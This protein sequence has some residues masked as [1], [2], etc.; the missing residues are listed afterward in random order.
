VLG[1]QRD[2]QSRDALVVRLQLEAE[3]RVAE[4][5]LVIARRCVLLSCPLDVGKHRLTYSFSLR[6]DPVLECLVGAVHEH[7]IEKGASIKAHRVVGPA[8]LQRGLK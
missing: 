6:L 2:Q 1:V 4:R 8:I 3:R 7:T 5:H